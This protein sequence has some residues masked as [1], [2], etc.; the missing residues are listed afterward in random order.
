[1]HFDLVIS[2][3]LPALFSFMSP[4]P[5]IRPASDRM[6]RVQFGDR[7]SEELQRKV[8]ALMAFLKRN[9]ISGVENLQPGY[10]TLMVSIS[11]TARLQEIIEQIENILNLLNDNEL[12]SSRHHRIP[13][14]YGGKYG[15]DLLRVAVHC[16]VSEEEVI[17]RHQN[18][19]Y[20]L[21]FIGF[22]P[23]FP[24]LAGMDDR[25]STPRLETPRTWIPAGSVGIAGPQTGVYP[26]STSGGWNLIGWT[27]FSLFDLKNPLA[28][29]IKVGDTIT[30][31]AVTERELGDKIELFK[32]VQKAIQ[33]GEQK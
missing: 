28:S 24:Y 15:Q 4:F 23:G 21:Y 1:M 5:L 22:S 14:I 25:L 7:I 12:I 30:F 16:G 27:P 31:Y 6:I 32:A 8:W 3:A 19:L 9:S 11:N 20:T 17:E 2:L 18:Q 10:S 29:V 26:M 33:N 13:V